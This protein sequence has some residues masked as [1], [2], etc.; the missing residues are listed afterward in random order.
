MFHSH[1]AATSSAE[2]PNLERMRGPQRVSH[3]SR[4][5][6]AQ[7]QSRAVVFSR[8]F[9]SFTFLARS[10]CRPNRTRPIRDR[11]AKRSRSPG[12]VNR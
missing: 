10:T 1:T 5:A 3:T 6:S 11:G 8:A 9:Q 12:V 2:S 4:P 7:T